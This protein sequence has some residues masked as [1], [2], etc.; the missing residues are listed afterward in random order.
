MASR[1]RTILTIGFLI[2]SQSITTLYI[3]AE[4]NPCDPTTL[5][6]AKA[7]SNWPLWKTAIIAEYRAL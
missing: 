4:S 5:E 2:K 3:G 1:T 6:K 7:R